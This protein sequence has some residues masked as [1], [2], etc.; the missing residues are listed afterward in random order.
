MGLRYHCDGSE[1]VYE[2]ERTDW[3]FV[4]GSMGML[5]GDVMEGS[6]GARRRQKSAPSS[7]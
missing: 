5:D 3:G 4:F 7:V 1:C 2:R 6:L